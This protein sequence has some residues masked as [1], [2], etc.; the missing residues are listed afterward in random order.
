MAMCT[1]WICYSSRT[2]CMFHILSYKKWVQREKYPNNTHLP[3]LQLV[4][5]PIWISLNS[6]SL[7][8]Y[9]SPG[10]KE[11]ASNISSSEAVN[12]I[13]VSHG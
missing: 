2:N 11:L 3:N 8:R 6:E 9:R 5:G 7:A 1:L 10:G 13:P 4:N 12:F